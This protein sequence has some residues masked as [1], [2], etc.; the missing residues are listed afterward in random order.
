MQTYTFQVNGPWSSVDLLVRY[1]RRNLSPANLM[2][3]GTTD[4]SPSSVTVAYSSPLS[5]QN[6]QTV[7][8]V[9]AAYSEAAEQ[10][11]VDLAEMTVVSHPFPLALV[12]ASTFRRVLAWQQSATTADTA[13]NAL[14]VNSVGFHDSAAPPASSSYSLRLMNIDTATIVATATLSNC[15]GDVTPNWLRISNPAAAVGSLELHAC[16]NSGCKQVKLV[17]MSTVSA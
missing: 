15:T 13:P 6:Q 8:S 16:V 7:A 14:L 11:F 12:S 9:L 4:M 1:A 17:G 3:V 2:F 10:V 5:S